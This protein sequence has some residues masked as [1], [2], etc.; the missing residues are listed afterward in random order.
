MGCDAVSVP[1]GVVS[2][3]LASR[4]GDVA[5]CTTIGQVWRACLVGVVACGGRPRGMG[6]V[7]GPAPPVRVDRRREDIKTG[8]AWI[9]GMCLVDG[10]Y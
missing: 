1:T 3:G 8:E 5:F 10:D 2:Q 6:R 9:N 4:R 7:H